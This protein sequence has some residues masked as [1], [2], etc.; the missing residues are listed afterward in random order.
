MS[1]IIC[2]IGVDIVLTVVRWLGSGVGAVR[3]NE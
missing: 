3:C 1:Y 2:G